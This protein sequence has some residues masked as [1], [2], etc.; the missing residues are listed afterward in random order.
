MS[1]LIYVLIF[2]VKMFQVN[3]TIEDENDNPPSFDRDRY[4]GYVKENSPAGSEIRLDYPIKVHDSDV[5]INAHFTLTLK[6]N[7]SEL[8]AIDQKSRTIV[9]KEGTSL[10]REYRDQFEM[11]IIARD[12][13]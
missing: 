5:G 12:R 7:G 6:G 9:V 2:Q 4:E 1:K 8:F 3:V 11:R 10:D 13:G